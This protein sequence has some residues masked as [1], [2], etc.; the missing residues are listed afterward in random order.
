MIRGPHEPFKLILMLHWH[1]VHFHK[2]SSRE[3]YALAIRLL[4]QM[5]FYPIVFVFKSQTSQCLCYYVPTMYCV[6]WRAT[7]DPTLQLLL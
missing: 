3:N 2:L 6:S 1:E 7:T 5:W 4:I